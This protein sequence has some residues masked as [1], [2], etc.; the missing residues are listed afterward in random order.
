MQGEGGSKKI[1]WR[2]GESDEYD[3][4]TKYFDLFVSDMRVRAGHWCSGATLLTS[5]VLLAVL[6]ASQSPLMMMMVMAELAVL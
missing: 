2:L 6:T 1:P 4:A 5:C 3:G